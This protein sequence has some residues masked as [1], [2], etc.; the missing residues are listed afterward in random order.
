MYNCAV[1]SFCPI[2]GKVAENYDFAAQFDFDIFSLDKHVEDAEI[3]MY[4]YYNSG[5]PVMTYLKYGPESFC[6]DIRQ[7]NLSSTYLTYNLIQREN[8]WACIDASSL[9]QEAQRQKFTSLFVNVF[10]QN[11][12]G[13]NKPFN[14][15]RGFAPLKNCGNSNPSGAQDCRPYLKINDAWAK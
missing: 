2:D 1:E 7:G 11:V 12:D 6:S 3:C 15:Y 10:G 9:V 4:T 5:D 14:C 8:Q 13:S